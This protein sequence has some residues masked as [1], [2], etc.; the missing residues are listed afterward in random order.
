[1]VAVPLGPDDH[2]RYAAKLTVH[3]LP[4]AIPP[5]SFG[6]NIRVRTTPE[7]ESVG[8]AG[9]IGQVYG[10]TTLTVTDV[11]VIGDETE[12]FAINVHFDDLGEAFWFTPEL[13]EFVGHGAGTEIT[14]DGVDK[15]WTR[16]ADGAW[17]ESSTAKTQPK[18]SFLSRL[19]GLGNRDS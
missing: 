15:K 8:L 12:D 2:H 7:T 13:L 9:L 14:L 16:N 4:M 19:F 3:E 6:D 11:D 17:D 10:E 5:I 18:R 1:M